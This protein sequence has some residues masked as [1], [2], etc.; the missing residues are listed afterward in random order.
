MINYY[1]GLKLSKGWNFSTEMI[2]CPELAELINF[3][4]H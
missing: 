1:T 4:F 3:L 2:Y